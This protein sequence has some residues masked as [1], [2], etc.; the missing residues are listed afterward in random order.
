M[1]LTI[2]WL[3]LICLVFN[4][5]GL[6]SASAQLVD[7][8]TGTPLNEENR[9]ESI[10]EH[11]PPIQNTEGATP[12]EITQKQ[13][14]VD[15]ND[16]DAALERELPPNKDLLV[17]TDSE[18]VASKVAAS[19]SEKPN[20]LARLI[21]I[22]RLAGQLN[23]RIANIGNTAH[24]AY[25][26]LRD[27]VRNDKVGFVIVTIN[28]TYDSYVWLHATQYSTE[29]AVAQSIYSVILA[30]AFSL[31][32]DLWSRLAW[33]IQGRIIRLFDAH[34]NVPPGELPVM[35]RTMQMSTAFAAHLT[36]SLGLQVG[37]L[38][39]CSY[40]HAIT[41]PYLVS[42]TAIT[43][44]IAALGTFSGFAFS[45]FLARIDQE[46]YPFAK[47][48]FRRF[49]EARGLLL[50]NVAASGKLL[51]PSIYGMTPYASLVISG[52]VGLVFYANQNRI[53]EAVERIPG[54]IDF[55]GRL[56]RLS[57]RF[58]DMVNVFRPSR[59]MATSAGLQCHQ[60]L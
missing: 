22:G 54:F 36:L 50:A 8:A 30:I 39:I 13:I 52:L 9:V 32:K 59:P 44:A 55:H 26:H 56:T 47:T 43:F 20:R 1:K 7:P 35:S 15:A 33:K 57:Q 28:T 37:R 23:Q 34:T 58:Q 49:Q 45:D 40:D 53:V 6:K 14:S 38:A 41:V 48:V 10:T 11:M 27:A 31:D 4:S 46:K 19:Q 60:V 3:L 12:V 29:V 21:P 42:S 51:Q 16:I 25:T 17:S 2:Q 24:G 18:L 5:A